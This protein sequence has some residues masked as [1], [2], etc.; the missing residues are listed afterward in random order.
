MK[1]VCHYWQILH[2]ETNIT[3]SIVQTG[4]LTAAMALRNQ[5]TL[6]TVPRLRSAAVGIW[7]LRVRGVLSTSPSPLP[8]SQKTDTF[9]PRRRRIR[10][11]RRLG[12]R[13]W[14]CST[15]SRSGSRGGFRSLPS[16]VGDLGLVGVNARRS[17]TST[18]TATL[19]I[20]IDPT[21]FRVQVTVLPKSVPVGRGYE[22]RA[23]RQRV[24]DHRVCSDTRPAVRPIEGESE[25]RGGGRARSNLGQRNRGL[26]LVGDAPGLE[27]RVEK[28]TRTLRLRVH[29][30]RGLSVVIVAAEIAHLTE[31]TAILAV[32][33]LVICRPRRRSPSSIDRRYRPW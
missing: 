26:A 16:G 27:E 19:P 14:A 6:R 1:T 33:W 20:V 3:V 13:R 24:G 18:V 21:S 11:C 7:S 12:M 2:F 17:V 8:Y 29:R 23:G 4:E 15:W 25:L 10:S 31:R 5:K 22:R 32:K 9:R 28:E 30:Q